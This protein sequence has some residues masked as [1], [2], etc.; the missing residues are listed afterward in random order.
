MPWRYSCHCCGMKRILH[1]TLI[2]CMIMVTAP[3]VCEADSLRCGRK[4]IHTGDSKA[5]V[6]RVC[7]EPIAR[8]RGRATVRFNGGVRDVAVERWHYKRSTRSLAR[9]VNIYRGEV[10]SID[11]GSR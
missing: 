2:S 3:P 7:G 9:T 8:D 10:V 1:P 4:L 5:D 6:L 11:V